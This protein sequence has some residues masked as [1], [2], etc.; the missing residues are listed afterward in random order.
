MHRRGNVLVVKVNDLAPVHTDSL[1]ILAISHLRGNNRIDMVAQG[2]TKLKAHDWQRW[3]LGIA[4][5]SKQKNTHYC[6]Y[7]RSFYRDDTI[8]MKSLS[9]SHERLTKTHL[10]SVT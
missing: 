5:I 10:N 6:L 3:P 9:S 4:I 8:V 1:Y 7:P 2:A